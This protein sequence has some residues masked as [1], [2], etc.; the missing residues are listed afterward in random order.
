MPA[1]TPFLRIDTVI[2]RVRDLAQAL[3]WYQGLL[4]VEP[5]HFEGGEGL[6]VLPLGDTSLTLWQSELEDMGHATTGRAGTYLI[7]AV[8]DA[9]AAHAFVAAHGGTP[10]PVG[11]GAGMRFFGFTDPDGNYLEACQVL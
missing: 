8:A 9:D 10:E 6:A 11:A 3:P 5:V 2:V 7:L 4:A 1:T